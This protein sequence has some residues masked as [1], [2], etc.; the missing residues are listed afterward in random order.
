M[1]TFAF[2]FLIAAAA[3]AD[4]AADIKALD[5]RYQL[6]V[7]NNDAAEMDRI[8]ADDF[9][10]VTGRGKTYNK[11]DLLGAARSGEVQYEHQEDTNQTVHVWGD[12]AVITALLWVKGTQGGQPFDR[13]LWFSDTYVRTKNGWKYAFGQ[14]SLP[15]P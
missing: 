13:K 1:K 8:L 12:T 7:K 9:V 6:A 11:A 5:T 4:D 3:F 2:V 14:A 10:L 15:L